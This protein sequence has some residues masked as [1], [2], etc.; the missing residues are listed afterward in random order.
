MS[1]NAAITEKD[2]ISSDRSNHFTQI[3]ANT[4]SEG[5]RSENDVLFTIIITN[6]AMYRHRK[7]VGGHAGLYVQ[8]CN[9]TF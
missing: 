8:P 1:K 6:M 7:W 5:S 3:L 9:P 4:L 2:R